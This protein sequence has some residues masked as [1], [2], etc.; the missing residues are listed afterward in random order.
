[1][2]KENVEE[3]QFYKMPKW[4][5]KEPYNVLSLNAKVMYMLMFDRLSLSL[6]NK[7]YD[8]DGRLFQYYTNEQFQDELNLGSNKTVVSAKK[9]L[10][11]KGLLF[12]IRQ[13]INKPNRLYINGSV[14][15]TRQE[16]Y[17]LHEGSVKSTRQEVQK[18]HTTK[19]DIIKT[20]IIKTD[21]IY[22]PVS[23]E[24]KDTIPYKEIISYLNEKAKTNYRA[25][26]KKTQSLIKARWNE[27][28]KLDD[29]KTVID[30]KTSQ[31]LHDVKMVEY[32]RPETLFG[33][34]FESYLNQ[35][36]AKDASYYTKQKGQRFSQA[37]LDEL[38]KPNP[39]YGF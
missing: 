10:A 31:W 15:S 9:E 16:V 1:M 24:T 20:D 14:K 25:S 13:G 11:E 27:G 21:N 33:T 30:K 36:D 7:W 38:A 6:K 35:P 3:F 32:L 26:G 12:E 28:F 4:L 23:A 8:D 34:K 22:S 5:F 2:Y 17:K 19:T 29:F 39:E 18:V 37:E